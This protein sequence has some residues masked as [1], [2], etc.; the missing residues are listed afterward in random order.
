MQ[1]IDMKHTFRI[2]LAAIAVAALFE[3]TAFGW[4]QKGHDVTCEIAQRHLSKKAQ[5][6][7]SDILDGKSIV[8]WAN[9]LDSASHTPEY[10]YS[11]TWHYKNIDAG[12]TYDNCRQ[13]PKGDVLTAIAAQEKTLRDKTAGKDDKALALKMLVHL[14]GDLHCPMHM[15]HFSD[16]GGNKHQVQYFRRGTNLHSIWDSA[17]VD[18]AHKWGY[19]EW[20]D[21]IDCIAKKDVASITAGT[22]FDWG[23]GTYAVVTEIYESTPVG[24]DLGFDYMGK[25][26]PTIERQL[27]Y[28][29]LRLATLLNDIFK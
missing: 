13:N 12:E 11:S 26:T 17:I 1:V 29:G 6:Q 24:A 25:W 16:K 14:V 2:L 4:G 20:A 27:L 18:S 7:I 22:P 10:S 5:K 8:Y 15:G 28:G 21:Q 9:W 19:A 3:T 23:R